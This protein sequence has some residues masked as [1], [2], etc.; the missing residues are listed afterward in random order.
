MLNCIIHCE[1]SANFLWFLRVRNFPRNGLIWEFYGSLHYILCNQ[2]N[3]AK[4]ADQKI[5]QFQTNISFGGP[6]HAETSP[7]I[8][9]ANSWTHFYM[10]GTSSMKELNSVSWRSA[11]SN[12]NFQE[13]S[14][15]KTLT[16]I[17]DHPL[18]I[19]KFFEKL[20]FLTPGSVRVPLKILCMY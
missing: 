2:S 12:Q 16:S 8:C 18:Y 10:I 13:N 14:F 11:I 6:Y 4:I 20:T 19:S 1:K 9:S 7:L 5:E 17:R 3:F 15:K